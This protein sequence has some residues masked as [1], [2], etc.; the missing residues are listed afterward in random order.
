VQFHVV[1]LTPLFAQRSSGPLVAGILEIP[2]TTPASR[3][4]SR[5]RAGQTV[6]N[7]YKSEAPARAT[8]FKCVCAIFFLLPTPNSPARPNRAACTTGQPSTIYTTDR[9]LA[10]HPG[11]SQLIPPAIST[12]TPA[13]LLA[14][15]N[16]AASRPW[17]RLGSR[18]R[19][20]H[21]WPCGRLPA[22]QD[23]GRLVS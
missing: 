1:P 8:S 6:P 14:L 15:A 2:P 3:P 5:R 9:P 13:F 7:P 21:L 11:T 23:S 22:A 10:S 20:F 16:M 4:T 17:T 12:C 18:T 19:Q